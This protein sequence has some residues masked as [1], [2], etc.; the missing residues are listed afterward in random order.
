MPGRNANNFLRISHLGKT[1]IGVRWDTAHCHPD[2]SERTR[3]EW[4]DLMYPTP[5]MGKR[6]FGRARAAHRPWKS[7]RSPVE[8][9]KGNHEGHKVSR[10]TS[11]VLLRGLCGWGS[12]FSAAL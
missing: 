7:W 5:P 9:R 10:R 6:R 2:R 12:R 11:F 1:R 4:R 3:A 8:E